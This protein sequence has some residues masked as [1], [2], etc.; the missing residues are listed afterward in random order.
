MTQNHTGGTVKTGQATHNGQV[1]GK[2]TVTV[3]FDKVSEN[4][5]DVIEGV[6]ALRV[7]CNFGN[8]PGREV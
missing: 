2:V 7:A 4:F 6:G 5:T 3:H 1:V 8:L